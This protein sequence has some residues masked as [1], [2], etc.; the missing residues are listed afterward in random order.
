MN[1]QLIRHATLLVHYAGQK[2]LV[3]PMIGEPGS[4]PAVMNTAN[5][6]RNPLVP[7]AMPL[8]QLLDGVDFALITHTHNDHFDVAASK[9]LPKDM[10]LLIQPEDEE[11]LREFGFT[12]VHPVGTSLTYGGIE[13]TRTGGEHG[14]GEIAQKMAP[15]SGFVL[16]AA[17]EP[18]LYI[19]GDTVWC[20]PMEAALT[21]HAP[22]VTVVNAG[23]ARF[24][25]GDPITMTGADIAEVL[26]HTPGTQVIAVHMEAVN[27]CA[28]TRADLRRFVQTKGLEQVHIPADG[29]TLTFK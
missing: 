10:T 28:E 26:A 25:V 11:K 19:A 20:E 8:D 16:R 12:D 13:F 7:M 5:D 27:H 23:G 22:H 6:H 1:I 29:E 21:A 15:V 17:G 3:D 4:Y 18:S 9:E 2:I 14:R 24:K